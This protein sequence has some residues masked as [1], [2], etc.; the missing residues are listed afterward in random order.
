MLQLSN[1]FLPVT[2]KEK[3]V[4]SLFLHGSSTKPVAYLYQGPRVFVVD[5]R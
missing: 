3:D 2:G 4:F 5:F 1:R